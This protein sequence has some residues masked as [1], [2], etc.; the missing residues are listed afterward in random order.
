MDFLPLVLALTLPPLLGSLW[1]GLLVPRSAA[2]FAPLVL[3]NGLLLGLVLVPLLMRTLDF[4]GA[5][6]SFRASASVTGVLVFLACLAHILWKKN[7]RTDA[8]ST[9]EFSS[10]TAK[11]KL[12]FTE[13][14]DCV[15][16]HS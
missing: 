8:T 2:G 13:L 11:H 4:M 1:L 14:P 5:G 3:G 6:L 7:R 9:G 15:H 12:I 10:L 16:L